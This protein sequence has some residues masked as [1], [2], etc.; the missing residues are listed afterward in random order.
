MRVAWLLGWLAAAEATRFA[1]MCIASKGQDA[2]T[3][4]TLARRCAMQVCSLMLTTRPAER[5]L[6]LVSG[7]G[8]GD[9]AQLRRAGAETVESPGIPPWNASGPVWAARPPRLE[10]AAAPARIYTFHKLH[11][12]DPR[13]AGETRI[14]FVDSDALFVRNASALLAVEQVPAAWFMRDAC[15]PPNVPWAVWDAGIWIDGAR[16]PKA[17]AYWNSGV[18]VFDPDAQVHAEL[19]RLYRSGDFASLDPGAY[20]CEGDLLQTYYWRASRGTRPHKLGPEWN[21]RG[22]K[23]SYADVGSKASVAIVHKEEKRA[24][25]LILDVCENVS[26]QA[27]TKQRPDFLLELAKILDTGE[28]LDPRASDRLRATCPT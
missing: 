1:S 10:A 22:Y 16:V 8:D 24:I 6:V 13:F 19:W 2:A 4:A 18:V 28:C 9:V 20:V 26:V 12:W 15:K 3:T 27:K 7:L 25:R 21:F 11:M 17:Q 23:C 5:P 14:A